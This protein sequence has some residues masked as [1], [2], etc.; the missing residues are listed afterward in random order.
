MNTQTGRSK[1]AKARK[2][3]TDDQRF[4]FDHAGWSYNP[5]TET[6]LEG[7]LQCAQALAR[8]ERAAREMGVTFQWE[9]DWM[10]D[11]QKEYDCY[12]DGG[13]QTCQSCI[14]RDASG[15]VRASLGCIDDADANYRRVI[16]AELADEA[17]DALR[18]KG[19][20]VNA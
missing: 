13:P 5:K 8:A 6:P 4:F 10:V 11:H 16:E 17:V 15:K 19:A 2:L 14:A 7:R 18:E 20:Q 3:L 9:D 12:E 1:E